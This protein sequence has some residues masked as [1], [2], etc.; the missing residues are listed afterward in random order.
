MRFPQA[1]PAQE[2]RL[3]SCPNR[4]N[5]EIPDDLFYSRVF[6]VVAERESDTVATEKG[7][8]MRIL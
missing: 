1:R 2:G 3:G 6:R 4:F 5:K 7:E 8:P